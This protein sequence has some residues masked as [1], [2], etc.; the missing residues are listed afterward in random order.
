MRKL[1]TLIVPILCTFALSARS[2]RTGYDLAVRYNFD[3]M[4]F[5]RGGN[6]FLHSMTLNAVNLF[7][8][9]GFDFQ[10]SNLPGRV[11][12]SVLPSMPNG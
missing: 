7:V 1:L 10:E 5:D 6:E 12:H 11:S 2:P 4:E 8:T 9:G 3:N